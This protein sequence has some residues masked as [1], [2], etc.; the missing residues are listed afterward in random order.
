MSPAGW[1]YRFVVW[2][3]AISTLF[4]PGTCR[5]GREV[6]DNGVKTVRPGRPTRGPS[7]II[8]IRTAIV[9]AAR[10]AWIVALALPVVWLHIVKS[11]LA[12][13]D[14]GAFPPVAEEAEPPR[15]RTDLVR[16]R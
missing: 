9:D 15:W 5:S 11:V 3:R 12:P 2:V 14:A 6:D 8:L 16:R 4:V 1:L 13:D 7:M 10:A